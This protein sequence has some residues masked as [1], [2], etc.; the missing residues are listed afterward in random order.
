MRE[1]LNVVVS[2]LVLKKRF[3]LLKCAQCL[4]LSYT[5][6]SA[7]YRTLIC[8]PLTLKGVGRAACRVG[9]LWEVLRVCEVGGVEENE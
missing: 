9:G 4:L 7:M 2:R 5:R 1:R 6:L 3:R 8:I